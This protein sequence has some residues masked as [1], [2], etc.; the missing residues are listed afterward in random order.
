MAG[1][2]A[3]AGF[4]GWAVA[5]G[6]CG[7]ADSHKG[8]RNVGMPGVELQTPV[9]DNVVCLEHQGVFDVGVIDELPDGRE[10][11]FAGL[12]DRRRWRPL[13]PV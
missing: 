11:A 8:L 2:F 9:A 12:D 10:K 1:F 13:S 5:A 6:G 4:I 7:P 3:A